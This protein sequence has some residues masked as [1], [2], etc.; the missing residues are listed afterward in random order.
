[1]P[2]DL[3]SRER[4]IFDLLL[5]GISPKEIAHRLNIG[6]STV[7][8]H[9]TKLYN[10]LGVHSIQELFAKY[11]TNGKEA[12]S[13]SMESPEPIT[14]MPLS[15]I[16]KNKRL[17]LLLPA[18]IAIIVFSVLFIW[19]MKTDRKQSAP[20]TPIANIIPIQNMG[21]YP[22]SDV[23][24]GGTSS[25]EVY[26]TREEI[27][28]VNINGVLNLK[29]NLAKREN[30]DDVYAI[31]HTE[32]SDIIQ[33]LRQANG[34]RFMARGDGK[35]WNVEFHTTQTTPDGKNVFYIYLL[36]TVRD[37][38]TIVDIPYSSLFQPDWWT[39]YKYDFNKETIRSLSITANTMQGYGSALLQIFYF[40]IY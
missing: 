28:G 14:T 21:F 13:E 26:V 3:T 9:R 39:K 8:F 38:V 1:M 35:L 2:K 30:S 36:R 27:D 33:Q 40:E 10:K 17:K 11:S 5:E 6:Y 15:M 24:K 32:Q 20:P 25:A 37:Q 7:D 34:I 22:Q 16:K 23:D 12:S 4:E 31:A 29:T 18:G 19:I